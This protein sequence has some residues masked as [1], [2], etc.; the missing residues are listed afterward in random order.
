MVR[1]VHRLV[2]RGPYSVVLHRS[3][4][5]LL[6]QSAG[7]AV[8]YGTQGSWMRQSRILQLPFIKVLMI[9]F[10]VFTTVFACIA[11]SRSAV[12][13]QM[14]QRA[15]EEEWSESIHNSTTRTSHW[16]PP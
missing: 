12:E 14:L 8:M 15:L 16:R 11:I 9:T 6:L 1:T 7:I 13:D 10:F 5:G 4:T 2:T 3:Y